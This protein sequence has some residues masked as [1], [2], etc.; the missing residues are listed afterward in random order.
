L[1][2]PEWG[3][4][5]SCDSCG[6][7][8]YDFHRDPITCPKCDAKITLTSATPPKRNRSARP[9]TAVEEKPAAASEEDEAAR[10]STTSKTMMVATTIRCSM[11][12]TNSK[13]KSLTLVPGMTRTTRKPDADR[14]F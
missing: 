2:K 9:E 7:K 11:T 6:A 5:R 1:A 14:P 13:A 3:T 10:K 12:M 4:K 8:F